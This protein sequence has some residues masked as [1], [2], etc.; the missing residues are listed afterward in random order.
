VA[1]LSLK[2]ELPLRVVLGTD[3]VLGVDP[4]ELDVGLPEWGVRGRLSGKVD[5]MEFHKHPVLQGSVRL[6]GLSLHHAP[7]VFTRATAEAEVTGPLDD[8]ALTSFLLNIPSGGLAMAGEVLPLGAFSARGRAELGQ[9]LVFDDVTL[10]AESLGLSRLSLTAGRGRIAGRFSASDLPVAGLA[11]FLPDPIRAQLFG[12]SP[13]GMVSVDGSFAL[14]GQGKGSKT[15]LTLNGSMAGLGLASPD[16]S[17]L[18][19][20][21]G[22]RFALGIRENGSVRFDLHLDRGEGLVDTVYLDLKENSL[23]LSG[24][25]L[26]DGSAG[27]RDVALQGGID[28]YFDVELTGG[29]LA[30]EEQD[31]RYSGAL[32]LK[33]IDLRTVYATF[34]RDPLSASRPS[35]QS[36][37]VA[38][39][40]RAEAHLS[41]TGEHLDVRGNVRLSGASLSE[42]DETP[43][44]EGLDLELPLA[45]RFG[46]ALEPPPEFPSTM[47][48]LSVRAVHTPAGTFSDIELPL[49]MIP[50]RLIVQ[51][52]LHLPLYDGGLRIAGVV[53]DEP[54]SGEFMA[55]T[56]VF[57]ERIDLSRVEGGQGLK[58]SIGGDLGLVT[59]DRAGLRAEGSLTG[60][61]F[62]GD[63]GV[64]NL[65]LLDPL[66]LSRTFGADVSVRGMDL[67][68]F[69][70][71][72]GFGLITGRMD[73]DLDDLRV[74]Y[75]Q[76]VGFTLR[77]ES[78]PMKGEAQKVSLA[79]VNAISVVGTGASLTST[80]ISLFRPFV[81]EFAYQKI[82]I[83]CVLTNDVFKVNG[84]IKDGGVE[85]LVRK[86]P[87]FGINVVNR[88]P[89]NR[90]SFKDMLER[91]NRVLPEEN[92][93]AG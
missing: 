47:G 77:A 7:F 10:S 45:Y 15:A 67:G 83:L 40:G 4:E 26:H 58:G 71:A 20:E 81:Q 18:A 30:R 82:G 90:I 19:L 3:A 78:I 61:I 37:E 55:S 9:E 49:A 56:R 93:G 62:G 50:N 80:A 22:G 39:T 38:G 13:E 44:I 11:A 72:M 2:G 74:A 91:I 29:M 79:A 59:V 16:G 84:L 89:D 41:G 75:G 24:S 33:E 64:D 92:K 14:D 28:P 65:V 35:M 25:G 54:L 53:V 42:G 17:I 5:V 43:L 66:G 68:G 34:L 51:G 52:E 70:R 69:S 63:L 76:P 73:L 46:S 12:W 36:L 6:A 27:V 8:L 85:Y 60:A 21:G 57:L 48:L 32:S 86:P 1:G 87:L 88:N 31:W 23:H